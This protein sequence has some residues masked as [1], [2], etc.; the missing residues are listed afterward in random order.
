[1]AVNDP[2]ELGHET[3]ENSFDAILVD[4]TTIL[5]GVET[6]VTQVRRHA[7]HTPI[8][9][10]V[11]E[12]EGQG[13]PIDSATIL[14][15]SPGWTERLRDKLESPE[16]LPAMPDES[17]LSEYRQLHKRANLWSSLSQVSRVISSTL[18]P[19]Q[20]LDLILDQA[21]KVV[22]AVGGSLVLV[23]EQTKELVFELA[24]GPTA[25]EL[26]GTRMPWG[27]GLVGEAAA[28]GK[29]LIVNDTAA[30]PRWFSGYDEATDFVTQ[31]ILCAPMITRQEVIGV[32]EIVNKQDGSPFDESETQLLQ[33]LAA[34]AAAAL[35]N[36]RLY[37]ATRRQAE[38]VSALLETS[39]AVNTTLDLDERLRTIGTRAKELV[40]ADE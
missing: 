11:Q 25:D 29:P 20:V 33:A 38:E 39:Q 32:L 2:D 21:V 30:D 23:D 1:M 9:V 16:I 4:T 18:E 8:W 34:Q 13:R 12:G 24:V 3:F 26:M 5:T 14:V 36:A 27:R 17:S 40:N 35:T 15:T 10:L 28:T 22:G 7:P 37:A 31:S 6:W 19:D